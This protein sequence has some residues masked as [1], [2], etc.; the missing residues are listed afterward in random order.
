MS[1]KG[2]IL[3]ATTSNFFAFTNGVL[4]TPYS[5]EVLLGITREVVLRLAQDHFPIEI[6]PISCQDIGSLEEAFVTSSNKEIMPVVQIDGHRIGNGLVG[7]KTQQVMELF[8][9]YTQRDSWAELSIP[10]HQ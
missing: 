2:E 5:D 3:E 7:P 6:A 8:S 9:A 4:R 1:A 10:R